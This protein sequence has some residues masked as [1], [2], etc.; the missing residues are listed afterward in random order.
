MDWGV[1][2]KPAE[3]DQDGLESNSLQGKAQAHSIRDPG[4]NCLV[5]A[6]KANGIWDPSSDCTSGF[7]YCARSHCNSILLASEKNKI[8][9]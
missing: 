3:E 4:L 7:L 6:K 8:R 5:V 2:C 9:R 1:Y